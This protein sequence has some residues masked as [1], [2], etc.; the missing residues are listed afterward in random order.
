MLDE[1]GSEKLGRVILSLSQ[2][3]RYSS[4]WEEASKTTLRHELEQMKHYMTIIESRLAGRVS[5]EINIGEEWLGTLIPKMTLQPIFENAVKSGLEP[6]AGPGVIR[7]YTRTTEREL[8][9]VVEDDGVG[10]DEGTLDRLREALHVDGAAGGGRTLRD[11][12]PDLELDGVTAVLPAAARRKG[13]GL[14]N[15][16]RRLVLQHGEDYGLRINSVQGQGTTVTIALPIPTV[17]R[18][19][20]GT[21][22][23]G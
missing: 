18:E 13:I 8:Q 4:D 19:A 6:K 22:H 12:R 17:R 11:S 16:H 14:P 20:H 23:R 9:I 3:F 7:V 21:A 5:T 1:R 2:M 15:V 10:M